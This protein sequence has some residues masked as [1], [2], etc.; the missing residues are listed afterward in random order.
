MWDNC[1]YARIK[2]GGWPTAW[3]VGGELTNYYGNKTVSYGELHGA[4]SWTDSLERSKEEKMEP[5]MLAV[6]TGQIL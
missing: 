6:S 4:S 2:R 3:E 1:K 5:E